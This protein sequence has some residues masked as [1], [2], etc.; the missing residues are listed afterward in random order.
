MAIVVEFIGG[1]KDGIRLSSNSH[2][3]NEAHEVA[4]LYLG[5]HQGQA[6]LE[7]QTISNASLQDM[8][9]EEP[10]AVVRTGLELNHKY[11]LVERSDRDGDVLLRYEYLGHGG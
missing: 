4:S 9:T 11:E 8:R 10:E 2:D 7:S 6:G 5:D 1:F 3:P